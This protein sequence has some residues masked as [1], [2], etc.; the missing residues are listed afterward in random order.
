[1]ETK[2]IKFFK[3]VEKYFAAIGFIREKGIFHTERWLRII[4]GFVAIIMQCLYM[5]I[6]AVTIKQYMDSIFMTSAGIF[7]K[8]STSCL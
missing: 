6:E 1:M 3:T 5:L 7:N 4:E 2:E 8:I